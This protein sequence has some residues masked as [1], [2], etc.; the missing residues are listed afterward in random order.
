MTR[1]NAARRWDASPHAS[2]CGRY[3]RRFEPLEIGTVR[4]HNRLFK[5]GAE[6]CFIE[7]SGGI[8]PELPNYDESIA[9]GGV[10]I[11]VGSV[12]SGSA[13][14]ASHSPCRTRRPADSRQITSWRPGPCSRIPRSRIA[15]VAARR[16]SSA[17]AI[18][19]SRG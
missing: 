17:W 16:C 9:A 4:L 13:T 2:R 10:E 3:P 6:S 8:Q 11:L 12:V 14:R 1:A 18:A 15:T 5:T 7:V 19:G